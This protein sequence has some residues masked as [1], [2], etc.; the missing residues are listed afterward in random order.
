M[1]A[2]GIH[3]LA[4]SIICLSSCAGTVGTI[5]SRTWHGDGT[6]IT[7]IR[8]YGLQIRNI[9]GY[10]GISLGH[11]QTLYANR[12]PK[13]HPSDPEQSTWNYGYCKG[14]SEIPIYLQEA[15]YGGEAASSPTFL[16]FSCGIITRTTALLS[17]DQ[18][19][20]LIAE[21]HSENSSISYFS[22]R[23]HHEL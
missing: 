2:R 8:S 18:N 19:E 20:A 11:H 13:A 6:D 22:I 5:R 4:A 23:P 12:S 21:P 16:G 7:E 17:L 10:H 9:P 3:M 1:K 15:I 14:P